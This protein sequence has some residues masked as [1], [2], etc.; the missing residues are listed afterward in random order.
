MHSK[1]KIFDDIAQLAG[2][3]A[4]VLGGLGQNIRAEIK[5]R[6]EEIVDRLDLVPRSDFEALETMLKKSREEQAQMLKR[7]EELEK[8]TK[9]KKK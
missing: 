5:S 4:G 9:A 8:P 1:E 2:G 3:A 7:I 6:V